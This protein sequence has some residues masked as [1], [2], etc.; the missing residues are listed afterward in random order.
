[1]KTRSLLL[2]IFFFSS[3]SLISQEGSDIKVFKDSL[4][5]LSKEV[6]NPNEYFEHLY[7]TA[8]NY[9]NIDSDKSVE[10]S[11]FMIEFVKYHKLKKR[12][13][14]AH[15]ALAYSYQ[16]KKEFDEAIK[17]F[18]DAINY[19]EENNEIDQLTLDYY[20]LG[21]VY[22]I[23]LRDFDKAEKYYMKVKEL[24]ES[25]NDLE[26]MG[27]A[28][29]NLGSV[30]DRRGENEKFL[31]YTEKAM[32]IF[33]KLEDFESVFQASIN[34]GA[35]Y[36]HSFNESENQD[37]FN[38]AMRHFKRAYE[39]G[40]NNERLSS[41]MAAVYIAL[42]ALE[43]SAD[44]YEASEKYLLDAERILL[45]G[46]VSKNNNRLKDVYSFLGDLYLKLDRHSERAEYLTKLLEVKDS[47]FYNAREDIAAEVEAKFQ[48]E[49]K[50]KQLKIQN[51]Q[52]SEQ[53]LKLK[54][55][56][57]L[58]YALIIGLTLLAVLLFILY[59]RYREK[60]KTNNL[61][62]A[63]KSEIEVKNREITDSI[64]YAKRIQ[65][66][67]LPSEET[68]NEYLDEHFIL[69]KPKDIV[70]G[71]FYWVEK[72]GDMIFF[73]VADCTGHGVPGAIVSV[74]CN[75][76]LIRAVKEFKIT[77]PAKILDLATILVEEAVKKTSSSIKDGMDISLCA[78][79]LKTKKLQWAGANN[80]IW[81][82]NKKGQLKELKPNKQPVGVFEYK[83]PFINHEIELL[84]GEMF[85]LF[86]DG[87]PD[88]F[89]GEKGKKFKK[90]N[91]S[92]LILANAHLPFSEQCRI[93]DNTFEEWKGDHEQVDDVCIMGV[94]Y[95][96]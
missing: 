27:A 81:I 78:F 77:Q 66:A 57:T 30:Y 48:N 69:Y 1:M 43:L 5:Q 15:S 11:K 75:N 46:S 90:L 20:G 47:L 82:V 85:Y 76:I 32:N 91:F 34:M 54:Q 58:R 2:I 73:G 8:V 94:R 68:A 56:E 9:E 6:A 3:F 41:Q 74:L 80:P 95:N 31:E 60:K 71:D 24:A 10:V 14:R 55:S 37:D 79:N 18:F 35:Y 84:G 29:L 26:M 61:L 87:F 65:E 25:N 63:Q 33:Q 49:Q 88:Q 45:D 51:L 16:A 64:K 70:S 19:D 67:I 93:I 40:I 7:N 4:E 42:G 59:V 83:K 38:E 12:Y 44:N 17:S 96:S 23:Y 62:N 89:G 50:E 13:G 52:L 28:Y 36:Y 22:T 92:K 86:S 53:D 39:I 21:N 72:E